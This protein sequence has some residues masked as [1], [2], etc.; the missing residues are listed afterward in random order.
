MARCG[1]KDC[2]HVILEHIRV[3]D[4]TKVYNICIDHFEA[5]YAKGWKIVNP[6]GKHGG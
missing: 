5:L 3:T 4:G 6:G 2:T 1:V